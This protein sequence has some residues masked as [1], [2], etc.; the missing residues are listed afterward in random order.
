[1]NSIF[2]FPRRVR[3]H[4]GECGAVA[5]AL[6]HEA[7]SLSLP[8]VKEKV[9]FTTNERK[10]MSTKTTLKRIALVAVSALGF[11]LL[12]AMPS[13]AADE[14]SNI[15]SISASA[16]FNPRIGESAT[17]SVVLTDSGMGIAPTDTVRL[18]ARFLTDGGKPATSSSTLA[19]SVLGGAA[20]ASTASGVL[21]TTQ[22]QNVRL[23]GSTS[24]SSYTT[25][26]VYDAVNF[27]PDVAG[28]YKVL[29]WVDSDSNNAFTAGEKSAT[30]T[31]TTTTA[32]TSVVVSKLSSGNPAITTGAWDTGALYSVEVKNASG[33]TRL[34]ADE[35]VSLTSS[36]STTTFKDEDGSTAVT[37][38]ASD[39]LQ[40]NGLYYFYAVS[41]AAAKSTP[42]ITAKLDGGEI[43]AGASTSLTTTF[44]LPV[45]AA[46]LSTI[47]DASATNTANLTSTLGSASDAF[48]VAPN[49][50]VS[51]RVVGD[52]ADEVVAA[53]VTD[54][55]GNLTGFFGAVYTTTAVVG[56]ATTYYAT[57]SFGG[58]NLE[59]GHNWTAQITDDSASRELVA[60][61]TNRAATTTTVSPDGI[62]VVKGSA[63]SF[64][65]TTVDQYGEEFAGASIAWS[66]SGA[67]TVASTTK[68]TDADGVTTFSYTPAAS[69]TDSIAATNL[70]TAAVVTVVDA[71]D[72]GS[73]LLTTP[74]TTSTGV[75]EAAPPYNDI[76][77]GANGAEASTY[78][79]VATV[80]DA[81]G[82]VL[83]GVPVTFT[84]S[85]TG[86][87]ITSTTKTVYTGTTGT[88]T[89]KVYGWVAGTYTVTATSGGKSD[90]AP[91]NFAQTTPEEARNIT[92][93]VSGAI[94][95]AK[96][97]D[98][99]GNGVYDAPVYA[100]RTGEGNFAG[101][102]KANANTG[103]D[104]TVEFI[105][106][107]GSAEVTVVVGT[108]ITYGQTDALATLVASATSTDVFGAVAAGTTLT[109]ETGVGNSA[110][111]TK[112]GNNSAK[113]SVTTVDKAADAANAAADAAAEAIDAANAA[114]DAANLAAEAADAA[115]V[116]AEEAR[117]AAD[118][119]TAAVEELA[120]QV[121]T[122]MAALKAQITTLAN[123]VAKI[124][125]KVRA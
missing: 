93:T 82:V 9:F 45:V 11:G 113:V 56:A 27:E 20:T 63:I 95:T 18:G 54:T 74:N 91:V 100:T 28:T 58:A 83:A 105:V 106:S 108:A 114:T 7:K 49:S 15:D 76:N 59:P 5:R 87:A 94:V 71:I 12:S 72:V 51:L 34:T 84:V 121:A 50:A 25:A 111:Y 6:H 96:V 8:A 70:A 86:A 38:I 14:T 68:I 26:T 101:A 107:G 42:T 17:I 81:A 85:G 123:T 37:A 115:T 77:A 88:A 19:L 23:S 53:E 118:A 2:K 109:D 90:D 46:T 33:R 65:G 89:A 31:L 4:G 32:P 41:T 78:S 60:T 43:S 22:S 29:V 24:G 47:S 44:D 67:N 120:T 116:A 97:T 98:R 110:D 52:T 48:D 119:A 39:D 92:A 122:L 40:S 57:F 73:V 117:D 36:I 102:S 69:G 3:I 79:V 21:T 62:R 1:M 66:V 99:F 13:M 55:D 112:V 125:K 35:A 16:A 103:R 30:V 80:K 104:G 10:Q 124:A 75:T 64:T 61:A